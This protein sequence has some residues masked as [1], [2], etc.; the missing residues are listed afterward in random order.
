MHGKPVRDG[1]MTGRPKACPSDERPLTG[2]VWHPG[3]DDPCERQR[4]FLTASRG[5]GGSSDLCASLEKAA[6]KRSYDSRPTAAWNIPVAGGRGKCGE[7][8]EPVFMDLKL[9]EYWP[10]RVPSRSNL[11][12][13]QNSKASAGF[14]KPF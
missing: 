4:Y 5:L 7:M 9:H 10:A 6:A 8:N 2:P 1:A 14:Q 12:E 3:R 11:Q 13:V